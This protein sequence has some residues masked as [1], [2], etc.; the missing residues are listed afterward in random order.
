MEAG[1]AQ[2]DCDLYRCLPTRHVYLLTPALFLQPTQ[3]L[4][5]PPTGLLGF[6]VLTALVEVLHHHPDEHVEDEEADNEEE[7][8][9]VEEHPG[10]VVLAGL[11][12]EVGKTEKTTNI[13]IWKA[14][15]WIGTLWPC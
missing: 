8:D 9:E 2:K 4:L 14:P 5:L 7:G 11:A 3:A 1:K 13:R 6:L 12:M 10:V 15:S